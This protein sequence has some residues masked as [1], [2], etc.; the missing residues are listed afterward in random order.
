MIGGE[1]NVL[2]VLRNVQERDLAMEAKM[3]MLEGILVATVLYGCEAWTLNAEI[4]TS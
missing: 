1:A 4:V 3:R 2:V